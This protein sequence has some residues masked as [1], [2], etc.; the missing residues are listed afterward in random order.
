M[1]IAAASRAQASIDRV[2]QV[3]SFRRMTSTTPQTATARADVK[4]SVRGYAPDE[5]VNGIT[6]GSRRII[7]SKLTLQAAGYPVPL[8]KGDRIYIGDTF[9]K[10][11]TIQSVDPDHRE[12]AG[13]Y[14][15]VTTGA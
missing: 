8:V 9:E 15:I 1:D 3:V 13:C 2:G 7:V 14:E 5:L 12:Y 10:S 6:A 4:A 11:T